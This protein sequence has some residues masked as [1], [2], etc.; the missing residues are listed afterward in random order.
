MV[1]KPDADK[2]VV[3]MSYRGGLN[4]LDAAKEVFVYHNVERITDLSPINLR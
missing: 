4:N 2:T 1:C 3:V